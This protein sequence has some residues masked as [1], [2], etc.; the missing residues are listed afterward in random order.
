MQKKR[1]WPAT[2]L[3]YLSPN[4][5]KVATGHYN[6]DHKTTLNTIETTEE[7]RD[8]LFSMTRSK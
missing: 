7:E 5:K 3:Q 1:L 8:A 4:P 6:G 2:P